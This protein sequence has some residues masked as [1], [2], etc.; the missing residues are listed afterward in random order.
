VLPFESRNR[1]LRLW[2]PATVTGLQVKD[3]PVKLFHENRAVPVGS[4][5]GWTLKKYGGVAPVAS[6]V[7]WMG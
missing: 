5:P 4:E 1:R 2:P 3:V 7:N 6:Q